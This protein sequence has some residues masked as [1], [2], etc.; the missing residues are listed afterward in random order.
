MS[1]FKYFGGI[2]IGLDGAIAIIDNSGFVSVFDIP[3]LTV[4]S[5]KTQRLYDYRGVA[6][7]FC[8][9][10][11]ESIIFCMEKVNAFPGQGV[12]SMFKLGTGYGMYHGILS[13]FGFAYEEVTPQRWMKSIFEGM[14]K[15]KDASRY[16]ASQLFPSIDLSK[17]IHHN[18][19]DA[20]LIAE[21]C[22]R[23]HG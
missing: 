10:K 4:S 19:A 3:L 7:I 8:K 5:R 22:R 11:N 14:G 12:S 2:D 15:G 16:K 17:K 23:T 13:S 1:Q 9:L 18:R 21:Y 6:N 20:L